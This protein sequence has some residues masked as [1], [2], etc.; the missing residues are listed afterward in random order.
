MHYWFCFRN[1]PKARRNWPCPYGGGAF[2]IP[3]PALTSAPPLRLHNYLQRLSCCGL[4]RMD[5]HQFLPAGADAA[6]VTH[7]AHG[8]E[9]IV[10]DHERVE[11]SEAMLRVDPGQH[12]MV[13]DR[14]GQAVRRRDL[15]SLRVD[16]SERGRGHRHPVR[17]LAAHSG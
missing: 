17:W 10:L 3:L 14:G 8:P 13:L 11:A 6:S 2:S 5:L 9:Q 7:Q 15:C 4:V 12:Q 16:E 1:S